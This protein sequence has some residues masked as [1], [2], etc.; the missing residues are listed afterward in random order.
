MS[1]INM[2]KLVNIKCRSSVPHLLLLGRRRH[3]SIID[4]Q[5]ALTRWAG[6]GMTLKSTAQARHSSFLLVPVPGTART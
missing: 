6:P 1:S 5:M 2:Y 3:Y 4:G